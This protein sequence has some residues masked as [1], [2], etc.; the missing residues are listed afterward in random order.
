MPLREH[1]HLWGKFMDIVGNVLHAPVD[2]TKCAALF[3]TFQDKFTHVFVSQSELSKMA[4]FW[5]PKLT[6]QKLVPNK[7]RHTR[8]V[9]R[10]LKTKNKKR[11][12][13]RLCE[14]SLRARTLLFLGVGD[15]LGQR[16]KKHRMSEVG[17]LKAINK[18]ITLI[19]TISHIHKL[20][21][22]CLNTTNSL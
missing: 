4:S 8:V 3:N 16:F 1:L 15:S 17:G 21:S 19:T 6:P 14:V 2:C 7:K 11:H 13:V 10:A 9:P 5:F 20:V 22:N 18:L 12:G